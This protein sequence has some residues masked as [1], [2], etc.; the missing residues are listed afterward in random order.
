M[1]PDEFFSRLPS[2]LSLSDFNQV[3]LNQSPSRKK[4]TT[5]DDVRVDVKK[6]LDGNYWYPYYNEESGAYITDSSTNKDA[7]LEQISFYQGFLDSLTWRP[8]GLSSRFTGLAD[9]F[10]IFDLQTRHTLLSFLNRPNSQTWS[11]LSNIR[12]VAGFFTAQYIWCSSA[13]GAKHERLG[14]PDPIT[15]ELVLGRF[16]QE[17][18]SKA[19]KEIWRLEKVL[20]TLESVESL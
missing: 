16:I 2:W 14:V 18:S 15:F 5:F 6:A 7:L 20:R 11:D 1:S 3:K 17:K 4:L 13:S 9:Q 8:P 19:L 12:L 10:G